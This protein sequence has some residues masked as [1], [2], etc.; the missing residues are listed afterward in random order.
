ME[1][2]TGC[3]DHSIYKCDRM[4]LALIAQD[5]N[6]TV[7]MSWIVD[8]TKEE[9]L[10]VVQGILDGMKESDPKFEEYDPDEDDKISLN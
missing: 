8:C 9:R 3:C 1:A 4:P 7:Y 5:D 2:I 6:G 10:D